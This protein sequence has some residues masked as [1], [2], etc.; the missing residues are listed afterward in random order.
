MTWCQGLFRQ[1]FFCGNS[2][3]SQEYYLGH[4]SS[5][6]F[7]FPHHALFLLSRPSIHVKF[8]LRN[9]KLGHQDD[10]Q[11]KN[12]TLEPT[13]PFPQ[14][15]WHWAGYSVAPL[16]HLCQRVYDGTSQGTWRLEWD[17]Y[18]VPPCSSYFHC[19]PA[20]RE[21]IFFFFFFWEKHFKTADI[22]ST[23]PSSLIFILKRKFPIKYMEMKWGRGMFKSPSLCHRVLLSDHIFLQDVCVITCW[24]WDKA[25]KSSSLCHFVLFIQKWIAWLFIKM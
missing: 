17:W 4:L 24:I 1:L 13:S 5:L 21:R 25:S 7:F 2:R 14:V 12:I 16:P 15:M 23:G 20:P 11:V 6:F 10:A 19:Y 9:F 18:L 22:R 3:N 8:Q